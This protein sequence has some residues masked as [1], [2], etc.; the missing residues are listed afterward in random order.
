LHA[1]FFLTGEQQSA[2]P[3]HQTTEEVLKSAECHCVSAFLN[4]LLKSTCYRAGD[5]A[6]PEMLANFAI[7]PGYSQTWQHC[8]HMIFGDSLK[9]ATAHFVFP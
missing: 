9:A 7:K 1:G 5:T 2:M 6:T 3:T 4:E 8:N